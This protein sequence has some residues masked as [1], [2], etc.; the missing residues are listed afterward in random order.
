M[1][2]FPKHSLDSSNEEAA[3]TLA[4]VQKK[5]G[6]I[7]DLFHFMAEAPTTL[8]AYL[9]LA[10]L[11]AKTSL[12]PAQTQI[13]QL[14][15]SIENKCDF[16]QVAHIAMSKS[17]DAAPQTLDA[18]RNNGEIEN[19]KDR[20][21]VNLALVIT[22]KR[23]WLDDA[24]LQ[25]FFDVGFA[26]QQVLEVILCISIKTL[27]NYINHLTKPVANPELVRAAAQ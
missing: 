19:V 20:A 17:Y 18:L 27:S 1:I 3:S 26:Q 22:R 9:G 6:F 10:D 21:L 11:I 14:A 4:I 2:E 8:E 12:T 7:P 25:E 5:Y 24:D 16:C 13:V 15:I 23:G